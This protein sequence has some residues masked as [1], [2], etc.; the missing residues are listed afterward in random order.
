MAVNRA[1]A[2]QAETNHLVHDGWFPLLAP[3]TTI[4]EP[5]RLWLNGHRTEAAQNGAG[6][7]LAA[8][9]RITASSAPE[10]GG[11]RAS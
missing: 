6:G 3:N 11:S 8:V 7:K 4:V 1:A 9:D 5:G 10:P 2:R